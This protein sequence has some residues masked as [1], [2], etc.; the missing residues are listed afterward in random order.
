MKVFKIILLLSVGAGLFIGSAA[1]GDF[2]WILFSSAMTK[3]G[4]NVPV[5][6][7]PLPTCA[8][9]KIT[10]CSIWTE[11]MT[12]FEEVGRR[13]LPDCTVRFYEFGNYYHTGTWEPVSET[14]VILHNWS[15]DINGTYV[16]SNSYREGAT[17]FSCGTRF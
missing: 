9:H 8:T 13:I 6:P 17:T 5:T 4:G 12:G 10:L 1:A 2:P 11:N 3:E 14:A 7:A 15:R 16:N